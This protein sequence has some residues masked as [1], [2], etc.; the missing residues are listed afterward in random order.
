[1][2]KEKI[3]EGKRWLEQATIDLKWAKRIA[4]EGGY[5]LSCFLAQQAGEKALKGFLYAKGEEIV[6]GHSI[7]RL[8]TFA[9][10]YDKNFLNKIK[11]W[12]ILDGYY[13]PTRY[14]NSLPDSIPARVY[15]MDA[16]NNALKLAEE[17]IDY[18]K[19][20]FYG[21]DKND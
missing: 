10:K 9:S 17:I 6:I 1:M 4:K 18:I 15:T 12:A 21:E 3:E 5:Y 2:R 20:K 19:R 11:K 14:P 16:A 8:C 7:E 13:V